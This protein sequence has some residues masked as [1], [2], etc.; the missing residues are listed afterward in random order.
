[1]EEKRIDIIKIPPR[2]RTVMIGKKP[3]TYC[4]W[5][6]YQ[7]TFNKCYVGLK[8]SGDVWIP[9]AKEEVERKKFRKF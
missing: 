3:S 4:A 7:K 2:V 5:T 1:M 9:N 6:R 8:Y